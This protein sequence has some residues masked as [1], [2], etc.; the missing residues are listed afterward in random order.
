MNSRIGILGGTFN[1][2][3]NGHIRLAL[4]AVDE[5][6]LDKVL[7]MP[8]GKSYFKNQ[9]EIVNTLHRVNMVNL[10]IEDYPK[11]IL[12][13][14][15]TKREGN[16]YTYETLEILSN[17]Y[18]TDDLYYII[19]A[20]TLFSIETWRMPQTIFNLS[21]IVTCK[22]NNH[23]QEELEIQRD[24]LIS[25]FGARIVLLDCPEYDISST[26]IRNNIRQGLSL[27]NLV[28]SNVEQYIF[29]EGLYK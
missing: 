6:S 10:A 1:P 17:K 2:I 27:K 26:Q 22:R 12:D 14:M 13:D 28:C 3:H 24:H 4:C 25:E 8:S 16:S 5:L 7:I 23:S 9:D 21:T 19:G 18:I 29:D 20:D 11:L 15:E